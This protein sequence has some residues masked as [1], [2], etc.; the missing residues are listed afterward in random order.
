VKFLPHV[1]K[2]RD[3]GEKPSQEEKKAIEE[4]PAQK[5]EVAWR[6]NNLLT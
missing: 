4:P 1:S 5:L 3:A 2:V 6:Y